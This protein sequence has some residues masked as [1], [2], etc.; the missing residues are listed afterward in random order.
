[1]KTLIIVA[2]VFISLYTGALVNVSF[3]HSPSYQ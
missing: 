2:T 1:M 3:F